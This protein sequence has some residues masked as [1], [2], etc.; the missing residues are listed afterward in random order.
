MRYIESKEDWQ[1]TQKEA[2]AK[3]ELSKK[4]SFSRELIAVLS[5]PN[6]FFYGKET[7]VK[8]IDNFF[9]IENKRNNYKTTINL[10]VLKNKNGSIRYLATDDG[11]PIA[12]IVIDKDNNIVGV[13]SDYNGLG[14][15]KSILDEVYKDIPN[16][17]I[18]G[19]TSKQG[20]NFIRKYLI[21]KAIENGSYQ[22]AIADKTM[23]QKRVDNIIKSI[24]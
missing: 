9:V 22:K 3:Y 20:F 21:R 15:T 17:S 8:T 2:A 23:T 18:K 12:G 4:D 6:S 13:K 14:L 10:T 19:P 11:M 5:E 24:A 1:L 7:I 16:V